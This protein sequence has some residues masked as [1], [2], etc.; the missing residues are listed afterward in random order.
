MAVQTLKVLSVVSTYL[1]I[2]ISMIFA[3]KYLVGDG[4]SV[5]N[6]FVLRSLHA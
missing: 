1:V 3:N 6:A 5:K 4:K 2:S